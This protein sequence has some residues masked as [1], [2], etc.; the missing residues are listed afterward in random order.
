MQGKHEGAPRAGLALESGSSRSGET[1]P[2]RRALLAIAVAIGAAAA[3]C[4]GGAESSSSGTTPPP[5]PTP[6]PTPPPSGYDVSVAVDGRSTSPISPFIYGVNFGEQ[7]GANGTAYGWGPP[8]FPWTLNRFGGDRTTTFNWETGYSNGSQYNGTG[9]GTNDD[10]LL[11]NVSAAPGVG[12]AI[13]PRAAITFGK[14]AA[15]VVTVPLTYVAADASGAQPA[16]S[17]P[18]GQSS[19]SCQYAGCAGTPGAAHWLEAV[20]RDPGGAT[21]TPDTS[22]GFVYTDDLAK[23]LDARYGAHW[24]SATDALLVELDN[25]PDIWDGTHPELRGLVNGAVDSVT[26]GWDELWKA[27]VAHG[28][29][30]KSVAPNAVVIG[31]A[32]AQ[33]DGV[34]MLHYDAAAGRV[35]APAGYDY[36]LDYYLDQL[37]NDDV[38]L[39]HGRSVDVVDFHWYAQGLYGAI[40]NDS[41]TQDSTTIQARENAT[42]SLWDPYYI[43]PEAWPTGSV[44]GGTNCVSGLCPLAFIPRVQ[45]HVAAHYPGT[46]VAILEYYWGRGGDVS[47]GIAQAD[48]LGIFAREGVYAAAVWPNGNPWVYNVPNNCNSNPTCVFGHGY[49]CLRAAFA[50]FRNFDGAGGRFGDTYLATAVSDPSR[51]ASDERVTAYASLTSGTPARVVV[52]AIN[53]S[54]TDA[55]KAQFT[56]TDASAFSTATPYSVTGANGGA[57][58]CSGPTEQAAVSVSGNQFSATLPA[59]SVTVFSLAP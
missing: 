31:G 44:P 57:G 28:A 53:K 51:T 55:L 4:G 13:A 7:T 2:G 17:A 19:S 9:G 37:R 35:A 14:G 45:G 36:Y 58:G 10:N 8:D 46:G 20:P 52:V 47:G 41:A 27:N 16:P 48:A 12:A 39:G 3:G 15:L 26:T 24:T 42:R 5:L 38:V 30:V 50:A 29:A 59:Q 22:D 56:V 40:G 25:E 54:Q 33:W 23:W 43:E 6:T 11:A 21:A 49:V 34:V 18:G 32:L 1:V